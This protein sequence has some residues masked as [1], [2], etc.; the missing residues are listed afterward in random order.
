MG[1]SIMPVIAF[2]LDSVHCNTLVDKEL[3]RMLYP[4][5]SRIDIMLVISNTRPT[6]HKHW[7]STPTGGQDK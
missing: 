7:I 1:Y 4:L 6:L 3:P 2:L 5:I